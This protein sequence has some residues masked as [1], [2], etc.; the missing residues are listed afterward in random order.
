MA[1]VLHNDSLVS[2][3]SHDGA[4]YAATVSLEQD[5]ATVS[6]IAGR[7]ERGHPFVSPAER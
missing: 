1:A 3:F 5:P 4:P 7:L 2:R 6:A